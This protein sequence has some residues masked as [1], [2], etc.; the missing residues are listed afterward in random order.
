[1][2]HGTVRRGFTFLWLR[3]KEFEWCSVH[4]VHTLPEN[5]CFS[6]QLQRL[7]SSYAA[8]QTLAYLGTESLKSDVNKCFCF[9]Y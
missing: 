2:C 1:M 6:P 7:E 5:H 9:F 4:N 8:Q 3:F